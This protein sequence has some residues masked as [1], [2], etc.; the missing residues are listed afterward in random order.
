MLRTEL[1]AKTGV[2]DTDFLYN[3]DFDLWTRFAAQ[4]EIGNLPDLLLYKR[5]H[6][7]NVSVINEKI[8]KQNHIR[9]V[10]REVKHL[11]GLIFSPEIFEKLYS[12]DPLPVAMAK[13]IIWLYH[14]CIK[15]FAIQNHLSIDQMEKL[16]YS[17]SWR[18]SSVLMRTSPGITLLDEKIS[19]YWHNHDLLVNH[20]RQR[21]L[22]GITK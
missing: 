6:S 17:L 19:M 16:Q 5:E 18:T 3:E 8:Q 21:K 7:L 22:K 9:I 11:T 2:Y 4:T 10:E 1:L 12:G 13:K 14:D 15:A 20:L